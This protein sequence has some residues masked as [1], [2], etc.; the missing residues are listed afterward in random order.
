M[1]QKYTPNNFEK[2]IISGGNGFAFGDNDI[3]ALQ[4][5]PLNAKNLGKSNTEKNKG[6]DIEGIVSPLTNEQKYF[7]CAQLEV[8]KV[9]YY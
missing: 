8:Y 2:A 7:T 4:G 9:I 5:N 6:Y 3:L 1:T